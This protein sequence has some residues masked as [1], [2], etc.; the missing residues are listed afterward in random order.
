MLILK[1]RRQTNGGTL[2]TTAVTKLILF[3]LN[4]K[5][6][7]ESRYEVSFANAVRVM[8]GNGNRIDCSGESHIIKCDAVVKSETFK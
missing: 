5:L 6:N 8:N 7:S 1:L 3:D 4:K 2:D